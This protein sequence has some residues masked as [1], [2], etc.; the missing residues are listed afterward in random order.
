MTLLSVP[1]QTDLIVFKMNSTSDFSAANFTNLTTTQPAPAN[2]LL[3]DPLWAII[4]RWV[5][6]GIIV[7][8]GKHMIKRIPFN[9]LPPSILNDFATLKQK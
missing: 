3:Y 5:I 1:V 6:G 2:P 4:L 9:K 7:A 8:V